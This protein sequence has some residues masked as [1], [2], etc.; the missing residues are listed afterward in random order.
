MAAL[1]LRFRHHSALEEPATD[2]R[3]ARSSRSTTRADALSSRVT[4]QKK[5]YLGRLVNDGVF[6]AYALGQPG[7]V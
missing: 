6:A 4:T 5:E 7:R 2:A 3:V 1:S